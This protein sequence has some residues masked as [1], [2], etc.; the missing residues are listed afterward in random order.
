LTDVVRGCAGG[1]D[2]M[3]D[4]ERVVGGMEIRAGSS[5][6][7]CEMHFENVLTQSMTSPCSISADS[8]TLNLLF[9]SVTRR[10]CDSSF[11]ISCPRLTFIRIAPNRHARHFCSH[12]SKPSNTIRLHVISD[13]SLSS[14]RDDAIVNSPVPFKAITTSPTSRS[15]H[16]S[17]KPR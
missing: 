11:A 15:P 9:R 12:G 16:P 1:E 10:A 17:S 8:T 2:H 6:P 13:P 3:G 5:M 4:W 14:R 7:G